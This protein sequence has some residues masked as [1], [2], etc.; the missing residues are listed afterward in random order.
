MPVYHEINK[1]PLSKREV[2]Q[3]PRLKNFEGRDGGNDRIGDLSV[4]ADREGNGVDTC[5]SRACYPLY[6]HVYASERAK[7]LSPPL[8][9]QKTG[10]LELKHPGRKYILR[11]G[12]GRNV[13]AHCRIRTSIGKARERGLRDAKLFWRLA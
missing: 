5:L 1:Y 9:D 10:E 3:E 2:T 7:S 13:R 8:M 12:G 4:A 11:Y 6:S